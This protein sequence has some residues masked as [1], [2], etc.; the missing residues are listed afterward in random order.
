MII[1]R[2]KEF[3]FY[4]IDSV[5]NVAVPRVCLEIMKCIEMYEIGNTHH[6]IVDKAVNK[7]MKEVKVEGTTPQLLLSLGFEVLN[8]ENENLVKAVKNFNTI[9]KYQ[10]LYKSPIDFIQSIKKKMLTETDDGEAKYKS[11]FDNNPI[12]YSDEEYIDFYKY[13]ALCLSGQLNPDVDDFDWNI[14]KVLKRTK[15]DYSL[16]TK[17]SDKEKQRLIAKCVT[18]IVHRLYPTMKPGDSRFN[19][20]LI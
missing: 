10:S 5:F 13:I 9:T 1:F 3:S 12:Q 6:W 2:Q 20:L 7:T 15:V 4:T 14:E 16:D 17:F 8:S 18:N 11:W 19:S